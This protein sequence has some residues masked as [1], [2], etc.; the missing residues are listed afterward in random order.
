MA[1]SLVG[2]ATLALVLVACASSTPDDDEDVR[3]TE[4]NL[5]ASQRKARATGIRD[6]AKTKGMTNAALLAGIGEVETNLAH[7]WSEA[8]WACKGPVSKTCNGPVIAGAAD[9]PCSSKQG[10]LGLFQ[11]DG[12]T[13]SQTLARDGQEILELAGNVQHAVDFVANIVRQDLKLKSN[14]EA[15]TWMNGTPVVNGN[16]KFERWKAIMACRYN[17]RCGSTSQA[18]KY[19]NAAIK[20]FKEFGAGF[21]DVD[22]PGTPP[23]AAAADPCEVRAA[24]KRLHCENKDDSPLYAAPNPESEVV[25]TLRTT[26]S[27]FDCWGTGTL[28]AGKNT[29]WYHTV[30]DDNAVPGWLPASALKTTDALDADPSAKGLP[31]CAAAAAA[32]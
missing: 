14:A 15:I 8:T 21:W 22:G 1:R 25:N 3:S 2:I 7:C 11:F 10:G 32:N 20:L 29:T 26:E 9:G 4:S 30:G 18:N 27:W 31:K 28:H 13:F 12:G 24:D 19:G 5:S 17:G 6:A 16:A 23:P